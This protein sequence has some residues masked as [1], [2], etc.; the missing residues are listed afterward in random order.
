MLL[1]SRPGDGHQLG[2]DLGACGQC[3]EALARARTGKN[4]QHA[5]MGLFRQSVFARLAN[6]ENFTALAGLSG[7]WI[8]RV[9]AR[10]PPRTIVLDM[11][12]SV[13]PTH[14]NQQGTA[15]NCIPASASS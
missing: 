1:A 14:G 10:H 11:D 3:L 2:L 9:H 15:Y 5:M 8:D 7:Q 6:D 12:S 4:G 13:S